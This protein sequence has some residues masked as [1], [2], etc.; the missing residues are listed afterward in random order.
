MKITQYNKLIVNYDTY[1]FTPSN[2]KQIVIDNP[3]YID[4][5][6]APDFV[7][8]EIKEINNYNDL[9]TIPEDTYTY[10]ANNFYIKSSWY[11]PISINKI[12]NK[13]HTE[14]LNTIFNTIKNKISS[15][16]SLTY[17]Y[18]DYYAFSTIIEAYTSGSSV[19]TQQEQIL[20]PI[21]HDGRYISKQ[22][23]PLIKT[24]T[25]TINSSNFHMNI[26]ADTI[27]KSYGGSTSTVTIVAGDYTYT[28]YTNKI[29]QNMRIGDIP[30]I[31]LYP[32]MPMKRI[33]GNI[34][35]FQGTEFNK[36]KGIF[37]CFEYV[38]HV[39]GTIMPANSRCLYIPPKDYSVDELITSVNSNSSNVLF[40]LSST[41]DYIYI[42]CDMPFIINPVCSIINKDTDTS[43][44]FKT[45]HILMKNPL[46]YRYFIATCTYNNK[47]YTQEGPFTPAEFLRW[48]YSVTGVKCR[49][50]KN[51]IQCLDYNI[52][53]GENPYFV[54]KEF[55]IVENK[56]GLQTIDYHIDIDNGVNL[57][58]VD[59]YPT[60]TPYDYTIQPI[61]NNMITTLNTTKVIIQN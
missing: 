1:E 45:S 34:G 52:I 53:V 29:L 13:S 35:N 17:T 5:S 40:T 3:W 44:T 57:I 58:D 14:I 16:A 61:S 50:H 56:C 41:K 30:Y 49:I 9:I 37:H 11:K 38:N 23:I 4:T 18:T 47:T 51:I 10:E 26:P 33:L 39:H 21:L 12:T 48:I 55:G 36:L 8:T 24:I 60:L 31:N 46:S 7:Q 22:P 27:T 19:L 6:S 25:I 32:Y 28:Q 42:N 15:V 2:Y 54:F 43:N 20:F 59:Y